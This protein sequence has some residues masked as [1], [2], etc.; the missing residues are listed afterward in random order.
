MQ[1]PPARPNPWPIIL[2]LMLAVV[3]TRTW[4]ISHTV[5]PAR[6][7]IG[8]ARYALHLETPPTAARDPGKQLD[9]LGFVR[10]PDSVHPPGYPV[11]V[12]AAS[13]PVRWAKGEVSPE[14]MILSAQLVSALS[15]IYLVIPFYFSGPS[16]R[17]ADGR[18]PRLA[19]VR[20][21]ARVHVD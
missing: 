4:M 20:A 9:R 2:G 12:L 6:D 19:G 13:Y 21:V 16:R 17:R 3:A 8:F 18:A 7:A 10:D 15:A 5:L 14:V 11:C 1:H